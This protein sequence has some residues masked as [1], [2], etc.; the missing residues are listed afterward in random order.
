MRLNFGAI[1]VICAAKPMKLLALASL[2][3]Y[4]VHVLL[5]LASKYYDRALRAFTG[6]C[7]RCG[8]VAS[9]DVKQKAGQE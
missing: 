1:I 4:S 5:S 8:D 2:L 9:D 3:R 6:T 7:A